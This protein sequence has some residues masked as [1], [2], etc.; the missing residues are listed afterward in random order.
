VTID[1]A[2]ARAFVAEQA[3]PLDR[4]RFALATGEAVEP[5]VVIAA[6]NAYAVAGG[7]YGHGLE[8]DLRAPEAQPVCAMHA[9]EVFK[10]IAPANDP[11]AG[12][13][14]EWLAR[15]MLPD[16]G[17]PFALPVA[18]PGG[19][20]P[21]WVE[22]DPRRS[23]LQITAA[24]TAAAHRVARTD[25]RVATHPWLIM[26][27]GF[28][29]DRMEGTSGP[30][31]AY[32]L[33]FGLRLLDS[34]EPLFPRAAAQLERLGSQIRRSGRVPVPGGAED[35]FI[36]PLDLAPHPDDAVRRFIPPGR[37]EEDLER[38]ASGQAADG[39]WTADR[40]SYSPDAARE[41]RGYLTVRAVRVA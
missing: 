3:R 1:L 5:G 2:A 31:P 4:L 40:V 21:F 7:G 18:D 37:V 30:M 34:M 12:A 33:L 32:E 19:C 35:E 39:G 24:V 29:L 36:R 41:W 8:P 15:T 10:E 13:L 28:C 38:L 25:P 20:A 6:L 9:F 27:T 17:L 16:G 23:S 26:A 14:C 22:A 11:G